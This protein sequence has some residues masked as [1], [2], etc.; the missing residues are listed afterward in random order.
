MFCTTVGSP[1]RPRSAGNGGFGHGSA[2]SPSIAR[3]SAVSSPATDEPAPTIT[4]TSKLSPE[5]PASTGF[6]DRSSHR[7][8]AHRVLGSNEYDAA[9]RADRAPARQ[10]PRQ[11]RVRTLLEDQSVDVGAR[12]LVAVRDH[13]AIRRRG[14]ARARHLAAVGNA[15]RLGLEATL[16]LPPYNR[17]R[18]GRSYSGPRIAGT[19]CQEPS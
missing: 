11:Q 6:G 17:L 3:S 19:P 7:D 10:H 16:P 1:P 5:N 12:S 13:D 2:R 4:S 9:R 18:V 15:A 8:H 14:V